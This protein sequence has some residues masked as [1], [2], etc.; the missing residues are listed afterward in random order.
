MWAKLHAQQH[1]A[2]L[3]RPLARTGF[4]Q[5]EEGPRRILCQGFPRFVIRKHKAKIQESTVQRASRDG[6]SAANGW[7]AHAQPCLG[8]VR[9]QQEGDGGRWLA[10]NEESEN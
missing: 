5:G 7:H 4:G 8:T 3:T 10:R 1:E 6:D 2:R 9:G